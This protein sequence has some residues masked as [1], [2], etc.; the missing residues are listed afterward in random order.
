MLLYVPF[1]T[2]R[3]QIYN[4]VSKFFI[5]CNHYNDVTVGAIAS[6]I[7]S[8]ASVYSAVWLGADQRKH[9]S[10]ASL[11]FV[12]GIHRWPANFPHKV[13]VTRKFFSFHN[14]IMLYNVNMSHTVADR[15]PFVLF[16]Y[17]IRNGDCS[18]KQ[19]NCNKTH[20]N[21]DATRN[22]TFLLRV[23]TSF[24]SLCEFARL[25]FDTILVWQAYTW[26][27]NYHRVGP[28]HAWLEVV[29]SNIYVCLRHSYMSYYGGYRRTPDHGMD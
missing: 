27:P 9:Q 20:P 5:S 22:C 16:V 10:S 19:S 24:H 25:R 23:V 18:V 8:L 14:V 26:W 11:A 1:E 21:L 7:T 3:N 29:I 12:R 6:Q 2:R 13:P 17:F 28:G 15:C 4:V